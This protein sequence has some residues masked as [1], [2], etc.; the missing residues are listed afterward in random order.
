MLGNNNG[1]PKQKIKM[2]HKQKK[3]KKETETVNAAQLEGRTECT[4]M[5][6]D[7]RAGLLRTRVSLPGM[8]L[9][10]GGS[11]FCGLGWK[12]LL[13]TAWPA[14]PKDCGIKAS[15]SGTAIGADARK[16]KRAGRDSGEQRV[17]YRWPFW[18]DRWGN[19]QW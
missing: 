8:V 7:F 16:V 1:C 15:Q 19:P 11:S 13:G 12:S 4:V 14:Q 18:N 3:Q 5:E 10:N 6:G 17:E 2:R 9:L